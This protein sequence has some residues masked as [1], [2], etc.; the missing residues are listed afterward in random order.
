MPK[1][2]YRAYD[3]SG[4]LVEDVIETGSRQGAVDALHSKGLFT[5]ELAESEPA[6]TQRWWQREVFGSGSLP[7]SGLAIFTREFA[8]L[9]KAEI[10]LDESLRI[11]SLQPMMPSRVRST[12]QA[13]LESV[14]QGQSLSTAMSQ[15][16]ADFPEY[17]WRLVEAAEASGSLGDVLEDLAGFLERSDEV[18]KKLASALLYPAILLCAAAIAVGVIL[19]VLLPTVLPLFSDAGTKPPAVLQFM[20]DAQNFVAANWALALTALALAVIGLYVVLRSAEVR[21]RLDSL[22]L[23]LP[24]IGR[25]VSHRETARFARTLATMTRN[26]VP[27][28]DAMRITGGVLTNRAFSSSVMQSVEVV[29]EGGT[30]AQPLEK[31]GLFPELALRLMSVGEQTGQLDLMLTRV[32]TI[33]EATTERQMSRMMTLLTPALTLVIG[34]MV[35]GLILSVMSAILSINDL[36]LQ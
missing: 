7:V 17:Y 18:R 23:R 36:A 9:V 19:T 5:L 8:T 30:L 26:G 28:L 29:R 12:I 25:F 13:L 14:R 34:A 2:R 3:A 35:G 31:T 21:R 27:I 4:A 15:R 11:V 16:G 22:I 1:F 10:P 33:Y 32:A 6:V 20:V 24:V